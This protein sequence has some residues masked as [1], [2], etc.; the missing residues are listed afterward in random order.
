[1]FKYENI[2]VSLLKKMQEDNE[3]VLSMFISYREAT[4]QIAIGIFLDNPN[5]LQYMFIKLVCL[6]SSF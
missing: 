6:L 3:L 4:C 5:F 1:M 2:F